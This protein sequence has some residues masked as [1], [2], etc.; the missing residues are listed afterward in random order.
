LLLLSS[1]ANTPITPL[2]DSPVD[3]ILSV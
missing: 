3:S 2:F 1:S